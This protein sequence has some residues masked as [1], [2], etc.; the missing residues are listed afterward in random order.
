M[1]YFLFQGKFVENIIFYS[2]AGTHNLSSVEN[3]HLK[4]SWKCF[5]KQVKTLEKSS[6]FNGIFTS[7]LQRCDLTET[8][9]LVLN[10]EK[11]KPEK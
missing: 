11:W 9:V 5:S 6:D 8:S 2:E 7:K 1:Y 10:A 3:T 4:L